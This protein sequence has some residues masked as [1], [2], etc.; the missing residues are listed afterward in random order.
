MK[1][2][3]FACAENC[4]SQ[5]HTELSYTITEDQEAKVGISSISSRVKSGVADPRRTEERGPVA[6]LYRAHAGGMQLV[7]TLRHG[8]SISV[9][10]ALLCCSTFIH[11][12]GQCWH[13]PA[14][15][16]SYSMRA[17]LGV[18]GGQFTRTHHN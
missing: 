5:L 15:A 1:F 9:S 13:A 6:C 4:P 16:F 7:T 3:H 17:M 2:P 12:A 18:R 11:T 10:H 8:C 14:R